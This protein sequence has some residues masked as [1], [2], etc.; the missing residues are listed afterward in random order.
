MAQQI[1]SLT[2][3]HEDAGSIPGLVQWVKDLVLPQ[4]AAEVA[5]AARIR[6]C[7]CCD[8]GIDWQLQVQFDP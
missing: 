5:D 3:I 1:K 4:D 2:S 8:C 6:C 7:Y